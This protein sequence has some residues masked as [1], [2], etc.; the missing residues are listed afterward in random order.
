MDLGHRIHWSFHDHNHPE[1]TAIWSS[2]VTF[3]VPVCII[4]SV[5]QQVATFSESCIYSETTP[6]LF[7]LRTVIHRSKTEGEEMW[8][9][10]LTPITSDPVEKN[11]FIVFL[12]VMLEETSYLCR[13]PRV[14]NYCSIPLSSSFLF[15][16]SFSVL[17]R[18]SCNFRGKLSGTPHRISHY[19]SVWWL[20]LKAN[21]IPQ[22]YRTAQAQLLKVCDILQYK[23]SQVASWRNTK[24]KMEEGN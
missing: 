22:S 14:P 13:R 18:V 5:W 7:A 3:W 12:Y 17:V 11:C 2:S 16:K 8:R 23:K 15:I 19:Y 4:V 21:A 1:E 20:T 9:A 10:S 6:N 24:R